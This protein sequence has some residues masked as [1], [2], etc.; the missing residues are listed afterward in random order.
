MK[1]NFNVTGA[2]RKELVTAI[3]ERLEEKPVYQGMPSA[4]YTIDEFTITKE[5][6][7]EWNDEAA[8]K[9]EYLIE[10]LIEQGFEAE[11]ETTEE[12]GVAVSLPLEAVGAGNLT[13]LLE[14]K[15]TLI[16]KA[17]GIEE[18][19]I[20]IEEDKISFPWFSTMPSADEMKA[21]THFISAICKISKEQKRI[22]AKEKEIVNE[23]YEFRCF[24]LRLGFIGEEYK[25]ERKILLSNLS[26]SAAFKSGA[27]KEGE[28]E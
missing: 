18:T 5:G 27:R 2:R 21:Y 26:G 24:L 13:N 16:K 8:S 23:K 12:T 3:A 7:L 10:A 6:A 20:I 28:Q 14:A 9:A 4:A 11:I 15:G 22:S 17:L 25:A 1:A 19:P